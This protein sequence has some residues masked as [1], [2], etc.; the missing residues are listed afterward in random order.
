MLRQV[1]AKESLKAFA[2][3]NGS[4]Q[5]LAAIEKLTRRLREPA[6][7]LVARHPYLR[8]EEQQKAELI[9][10]RQLD[11]LTQGDRFKV[12]DTLFPRIATQVER[13]W[14]LL[15]AT[16][17]QHGHSR[18][19]FR[20]PNTPLT[21]QMSRFLWLVRLWNAVK[22]YDQDVHWL[23]AWAPYLG[24]DAPD[25]LG[26]LFAAAID[27]GGQVGNTVFDTL[28]ASARGEHEI[29]IMGRHVTRGLLLASREDGWEFIERLLLAAQAQEGL[30]QVILETV[31]EAHPQAFRRMLRLILENNLVRF[32]AAVRAI[33][34]WFGLWLESAN[35]RQAA[36]VVANVARLLDD[37]GARAKALARGDGQ[38]AYLALWA[39]AFEDAVAA[40]GPAS[41]LLTDGDV[42]RRFAA[43]HL[44]AQVGLVAAQDALRAALDD[45]D[46]RIVTRAVIG[47]RGR[48]HERLCKSD[49]FERVERALTRFPR[50]RT[51]LKPILWPWLALSAERELP[52]RLLLDS[53]G[54]RSPK[55]II[56]YLPAMNPHDRSR[57]AKLLAGTKRWDTDMRAVLFSLLGDKAYNVREAA[58]TAVADCRLDKREAIGVEQLLARKAA[59]LRRGA[60]S[61][62][63]SQPDDAALASAARLL[64]TS[65]SGQ[66][67]AG[68]ELLRELNIAKRKPQQCRAVAE[69]YRSARTS[70]DADEGHLLDGILE[71]DRKA[72]L[73]DALGLLDPGQRTKPTPPTIMKGQ[74]KPVLVTDAAAALL[75]SFDALVSSH[76]TTPIV[77]PSWDAERGEALLGNVGWSFPRPRRNVPIEEDVARLPLHDIWTTWW[78]HDRPKE[79]RDPDGFELLRALAP[80]SAVSFMH[81]SG[82]YPGWLEKARKT[83]FVDIREHKLAYREI[84]RTVL[85]WLLRLYP[86]DGAADF[87]VNAIEFSATLIPKDA[88]PK[89]NEEQS[90][91][92]ARDP[93]MLGWLELARY[94]REARPS[95]WESGHHARLWRC[96]RWID[97]PTPGASRCRP[98]LEE[99]VAAF[100]AGVATEADVLDQI[101]GPRSSTRYGART[102]GELRE[103]SGRGPSPLFE[104]YPV[105]R[106]LVDRCRERIVQIELTRGDLPT[107]A[108]CPATAL[109]S[110]G[111]LK[112]LVQLLRAFGRESFVRGRTYGCDSKAAVFSHLVRI[113]FP[114]ETETPELFAAE[115]AEAGIP[116]QRLIQLALY[117]PQWA[118]HVE[119]ALEW[120]GLT[121]VVFWILAHTKD[122]Q[123]RVDQEIREAWAAQ[124][125][126]LTPVSS[127]NLLDGAVDVDWFWR[128][129]RALGPQRWEE[130]Y[131]AAKFASGG[132]GHERARR[133][134]DAM[135]GRA[136]KSELIVK[137]VDKR[138][139]DS[140]R[141]L[142]LLPLAKGDE[143]ERDIRERYDVIQEFLRTSRKFGPQRQESEKL[144]AGIALE[145]LARTA[146]YPDP[147][148]LQWA[149]EA[150]AVA[151][152]ATGPAVRT[153]SE[154]TVSLAI[155]AS[156]EPNLT[157]T[158]A[159][160][161]LK[162]IPA[163]VKKDA[164]IVELRTRQREI[165]RQRSRVR[166][167]LEQAM[168]RGDSFTGAELK[169]LLCHPVLAPMLRGLVF[170][171]EG[172]MGYPVK[173]GQ[174]LESLGGALSPVG[175]SERLRIAHA[176]DLLATG[177]WH[178]YQQEC[179][180]RERIQP[181]KQVFR[182]LYVPTQAE[183]EDS[184]LSRRYAGHQVQ[185]KQALALLGQLGWV[186]HPEEGLRKTFHYA[187]VSAWLAFLGGT[188]TPAEAEGL[189]IEGIGF[190]RHGEWKP[191]SLAEIP[192]RLFSEV[193]RDVDLVVSVAHQGGVDPEAS[194]S[195]VE[196]RAALIRETCAT[197]KVRNVRLQGT[198]AL[199]E[200]TLGSYS[201]HLGSAVVHRQPGGALCIVPSH[202]QHRG[203]LFL[204]FA[205]DDPRTAEVL[206]KTLLL[207]RDSEIKD[208]S[209]LEQI[210]A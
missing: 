43:T 194:A 41:R 39:F 198:H 137:I 70:I 8:S 116:Q 9:A 44:L 204:P 178:L 171:A 189:T 167:S 15:L 82:S 184:K 156:G 196:M 12:F 154:V 26:V 176:C 111:G 126:E 119:R 179:F 113:T 145:N 172:T 122:A 106:E 136:E 66:R 51:V 195:T 105:L 71:A 103:L 159:G 203:R 163:A 109:R 76:R 10:A 58:L 22:I 143:Q 102:F 75:K 124:I 36:E 104:K 180:T 11:A 64:E 2:D 17:Y 21:S 127:Q 59:D 117:A 73:D 208:P 152:L 5:R 25:A 50:Q 85:Y 28:C 121:E 199:I 14:S 161:S 130:V 40:V 93:R 197:L 16:P 20:A 65:D 7:I 23:A 148:R 181:F 13:A 162:S 165:R 149:M 206:S 112:P 38:Q 33:D 72:T 55:R 48:V 107:A 31:D 62:L 186:N 129:H 67:L 125:A 27:S 188:F 94:H 200:G 114:D 92:W 131:G 142:G 89:G 74:E 151:D 96:L 190:S 47:L 132:S 201:V 3:E 207:A 166:I 6:K 141:A 1:A 24:W 177:Q 69:R 37:G 101:L 193:M 157:V 99:T 182:E 115:V 52:G 42:E 192:P 164:A 91:D 205:D 4:A 97:E 185:P 78:G 150:R 139:Q 110:A 187:G 169:G 209:I 80:F 155:D 191:L 175:D 87:F 56:P 138:H 34:V 54:G 79:T 144:A 118:G 95:A 98:R 18:L 45:A 81:G 84:V 83:L 168:C 140:V 134:A 128:A 49:L 160:R 173:G 210:L 135:I 147:L 202:A 68:L 32:S 133:F 108:S 60:I 183:R 77:I 153:I 170:V 63:L 146:G 57:A 158:K 120:P 29:G 53:V 123:W 35:P 88:V 19:A 174:A 46:L 61:L 100:G 30:R 90:D 86:P